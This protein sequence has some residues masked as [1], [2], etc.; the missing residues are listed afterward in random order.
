MEKFD[1]TIE[2]LKNKKKHFINMENF[3]HEADDDRY[4]GYLYDYLLRN[5]TDDSIIFDSIIERPVYHDN[6]ELTGVFEKDRQFHCIV[7][8]RKTLFDEMVSIHEITHLINVLSSRNNDK[9]TS[10]ET[11]P[12]F[13]EYE[14]LKQIHDFYAT[15][16]EKYRENTSIDAARMANERNKKACIAYIQAQL[17]LAKRK[18]NYNI[19]TLNR[20][21]TKTKRLERDLN[22]K[23]YTI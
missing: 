8:E 11:I 7:P 1:I 13:N 20:I 12:F 16:Y 5:V 17:V 15:Y 14:Y 3:K 6:Y 23:G 18:D 4:Y 22:R 21:N 2:E 10:R 19:D 9:S